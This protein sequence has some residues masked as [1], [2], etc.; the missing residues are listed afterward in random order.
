MPKRRS[1]LR[2]LTRRDLLA[3]FLGLPAALAGCSGPPPGES[4]GGGIVGNSEGLG[5][6]L[7]HGYRPTPAPDAWR[8]VGVVIVGGGVA[9][10]AAAYRFEKAEFH[11]FVLLEM[12]DAPGGTSRSGRSAVAAYPW[13]AHYIPAPLKENRLLVVLFGEMGMLE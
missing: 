4:F 13:G 3:A 7:R 10:L 11:N 8:R 2:S 9:G 1:S 12:E 5:P 6:R